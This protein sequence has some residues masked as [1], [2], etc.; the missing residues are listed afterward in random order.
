MVSGIWSRQIC[1]KTAWG[2]LRVWTADFGQARTIHDTRNSVASLVSR[3]AAGD[4]AEKQARPL[5]RRAGAKKSIRPLDAA[6]K[7]CRSMFRRDAPQSSLIERKTLLIHSI[8]CYQRACAL[9]PTAKSSARRDRGDGGRRTQSA[10]LAFDT[11]HARVRGP[12]MAA[13]FHCWDSG[14]ARGKRQ[15]KPEGE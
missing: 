7:L 13:G 1:G 9:R 11:I 15:R 5:G 6:V 14:N 8:L 4:D 10:L 3:R 2:V 12:S